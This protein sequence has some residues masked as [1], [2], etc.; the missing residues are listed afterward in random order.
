MYYYEKW[1]EK[2]ICLLLVL[3]LMVFVYAIGNEPT[4]EEVKSVILLIPDGTGITHMTLTR[5]YN[6]GQ[7]LAVDE[8]ICGLVRTYSADA[9]IADS[10]PAGTAM[11]TGYKSHAGFIS[12]LPDKADMPG[13]TPIAPEDA[14]KPVATVLEAA[15]LKGKATGLVVTCQIQHATPAAFSSHYPER[16][17]YEI[18]CEQQVY[19]NLNVVL[20]GG[21]QYLQADRRADKEDLIAVIKKKGYDY[22][23]TRDE[24]LKST[25]PKIWGAFAAVAMDYDFDRDPTVQPSLEEMT[26][27][28]IEILSKDPDGFFLMVEGSQVDW[29]SHANDPIGVISEFRAFDKAVKVALDFAKANGNTVVIVAPDHGNGGLSIGNADTERGYDTLP[30]SSIVDPLRD[31]KLT[32]AGV[33]AKL[34]ASLPEA[35]F[36]KIIQ[37]NYGLFVLTQDEYTVLKAFYDEVQQSPKKLDQLVRVIAPM[38]SKRAGLGWT[39]HGHT[40]EEVFLGVYH[41]RN[42]RLTGVVENTDIAKYIARILRLNLEDTTKKLF[43]PAEAAFSSRGAEMSI[44][45]QDANNPV[46]VVKKGNNTL[47]MPVFKNE[48]YI[49]DKCVELPGLVLS[50]GKSYFVPQ[51]AVDL[52]DVCS[53]ELK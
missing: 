25:A 38:M 52:I 15:K 20:G 42:F 6:G 26:K 27:K 7:P 3:V 30:L 43:V 13:Q 48:A 34:N 4:Q 17:K 11:A 2:Q 40:G 12:V 18:L 32:A 35:E 51:E 9:P 49:N 22:V 1:S 53:T 46:I 37:E 44:D 21:W 36:F 31:A 23:T 29:A 47:R 28:A 16:D 39:T 24:M 41:P 14:R 33:R 19:N 10:A 8:L 45:N 5:W 50:N